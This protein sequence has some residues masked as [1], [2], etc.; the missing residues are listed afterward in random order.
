LPLR[1]KI[2][3]LLY[4]SQ[5]TLEAGHFL[6]PWTSGA[7]K[8]TAASGFELTLPPRQQIGPDPQFPGH[9][10]TADTRLLTL[11]NGALLELLA[12]SSSL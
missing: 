6:I 12:V 9:L 7:T 11:F 8:S 10:G 3:F 1:V 5:L 2:P 4:T